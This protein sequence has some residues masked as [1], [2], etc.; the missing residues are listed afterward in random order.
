MLTILSLTQKLLP[1]IYLQLKVKH[2]THG[3]Y[4]TFNYLFE[5]FNVIF[6]MFCEVLV[7]NYVSQYNKFTFLAL[8]RDCPSLTVKW[9]PTFSEVMRPDL[10]SWSTRTVEIM[11]DKLKILKDLARRIERIISR[12]T[13]KRA[14][15]RSWGMFSVQSK[16][17]SPHSL[18]LIF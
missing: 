17:D 2:K 3:F 14:E 10:S 13:K 8:Y 18:Y 6:N 1:Q 9:V 16:D 12:E 15:D 7:L 11:A 5:I 4:Y